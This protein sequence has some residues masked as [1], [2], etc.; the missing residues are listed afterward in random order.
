MLQSPVKREFELLEVFINMVETEYK[1]PGLE[2]W[3]IVIVVLYF[4]I[5]LGVGLFVSILHFGFVV[6]LQAAGAVN[7]WKRVI[8]FHLCGCMLSLNI[9][10][11]SGS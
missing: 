7:L 1:A 11:L 6:I 9:V 4:L 5:V 3:D 8:C 10:Y 2:A